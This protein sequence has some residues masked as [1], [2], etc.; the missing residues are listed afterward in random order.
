[1]KNLKL[2]IAL[3]SIVLAISCTNK[4]ETLT[5][6]KASDYYPMQVGKFVVY[7]LDS[8]NYIG[9]NLNPIITTYFVKDEVQALITDNLNRPSYRIYRYTKR[10]LTDL[11]WVPTSTY[12]VTPLANTIEHIENNLRVIKLLNPIKDDNTWK[13]NSYIESSGQF[14]QLQYLFD[15]DFKYSNTKTPK[16]YTGTT[17]AETVTV[18]QADATDGVLNDPLSYSEKNYSVE[19]YAKG[20]GLVYK[21]FLHWSY[22][23]PQGSTLGYRIGYGIKL[24]FVSK[25]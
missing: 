6:E 21:D 5:I 15:W 20:T 4:V 13:G 3:T 2:L 22:Q 19:I 9:F 24:T 12:F 11:T 10:A 18:T 17:F 16:T 8:T 23:P 25:N 1:M 7:K 14:S